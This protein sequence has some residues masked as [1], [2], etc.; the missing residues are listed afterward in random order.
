LQGWDP[1]RTLRF[2]NAAG[3]IVVTRHSCSEAMP[4]LEEV[5]ELLARTS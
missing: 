2:A 5:E 3:A 1:E 4:T